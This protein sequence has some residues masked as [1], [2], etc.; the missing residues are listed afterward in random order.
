MLTPKAWIVLDA[1]PLLP[2]GKPD[3][4]ALTELLRAHRREH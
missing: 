2:N 3:R 4:R 1:L